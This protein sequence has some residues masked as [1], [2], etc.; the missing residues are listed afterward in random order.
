M[1][2]TVAGTTRSFSISESLAI[3]FLI[4]ANLCAVVDCGRNDAQMGCRAA[5]A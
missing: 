4:V 5:A 2:A 3:A 1:N